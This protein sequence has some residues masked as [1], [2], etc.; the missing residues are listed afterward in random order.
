VRRVRSAFLTATLVAVTGCGGAT[1]G[2]A[3]P[4]LTTTAA[5]AATGPAVLEENEGHVAEAVPP[6]SYVTTEGGFDKGLGLTI[7][8][9]WTVRQNNFAELKLAPEGKP[10]DIL[11]LFSRVV[12]VVPNNQE[13]T[14]GQ[15]IAGVGHTAKDLVTFLTT[16]KDF[17]VFD[18][19][20]DVTIGTSIKATRLSLGVSATASFAD[21]ECPDNPHCAA[22]VKSLVWPGDDFFA[23]GGDEVVTLYIVEVE[24][25]TLWAVLDAP[26]KNDLASLQIAAD[27][28]LASLSLP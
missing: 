18:A 12:A 14:V 8:A 16:T 13:G 22:L 28:I 11:V 17:E 26:N 21:P 6:G 23:I 9:G 25:G 24:D 4:T 7:P 5:P 27:P 10:D 19:P 2:T 3:A 15:E 20:K 1:G